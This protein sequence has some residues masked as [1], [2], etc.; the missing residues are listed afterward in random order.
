MH[1]SQDILKLA[2][3]I[4]SAQSVIKGQTVGKLS[5]IAEQMDFLKQVSI[6]VVFWLIGT[7]PKFFKDKG[8]NN[9][10]LKVTLASKQ[11][12]YFII[13]NLDF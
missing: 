10:N 8:L 6:V 12:N 13:K 4:Q 9:L 11:L 5:L 7:Q 3:D 2:A 1:D